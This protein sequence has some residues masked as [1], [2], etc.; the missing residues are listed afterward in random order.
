MSQTEVELVD[1]FVGELYERVGPQY[2][3]VNTPVIMI[4]DLTQAFLA[5]QRQVFP[6]HMVA[7]KLATKEM[8]IRYFRAKQCFTYIPKRFGNENGY[9]AAATEHIPRGRE[10]DLPD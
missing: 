7:G 4:A 3:G 5:W 8:L 9:V 10:L 1:R 2:L 6:P